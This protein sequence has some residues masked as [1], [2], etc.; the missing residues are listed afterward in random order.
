MEDSDELMKQC[1]LS[2]SSGG[3]PLV[4]VAYSSGMPAFSVGAGNAVVIVDKTADIAEAAHTIMLAA[5]ALGAAT[6][7]RKTCTGST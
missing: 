5:V 3:T 1:N 6:S 7:R 4:K 2:I